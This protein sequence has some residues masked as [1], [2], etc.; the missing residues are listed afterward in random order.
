MEVIGCE[1]VYS[2]RE[3]RKMV[4]LMNVN[5]IYEAKRRREIRDTALKNVVCEVMR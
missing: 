4:T 3:D 1:K 2:G 5:K